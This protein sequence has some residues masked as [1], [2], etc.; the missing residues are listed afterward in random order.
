MSTVN[1]AK[2]AKVTMTIS[3]QEK[4]P[5]P[6]DPTAQIQSKS[7]P[8]PSRVAIDTFRAVNGDLDSDLRTNRGASQ[9]NGNDLRKR[10]QPGYWVGLFSMARKE[11]EWRKSAE[12]SA[13]IERIQSSA[14]GRVVISDE[15][16]QKAI[17][18]DG[19]AVVSIGKAGGIMLLWRK[20]TISGK[21]IFKDCQS[22]NYLF[23]ID[24]NRTFLLSCLYAS[25]NIKERKALWELL[26][27]LDINGISWL[28]VGDMNCILMREE[29][30]G[31]R[32]FIINQSV[33]DF[34]HFVNGTGLIDAG[35]VG[36]AFT[37]TNKRENSRKISAM[38]DRVL[39]D[40]KWLEWRYEMKVE[41]KGMID[42]DHR[43]FLIKC[44]A[45]LLKKK[46][47]KDKNFIC[48]QFWFEYP[49]FKEVVEQYWSGNNGN[50]LSM[51]DNIER[52]KPILSNWN[53]NVVGN[54]ENKWNETSRNLRD[55][56]L[57][58]E[59]GVIYDEEVSKLDTDSESN[60][61]HTEEFVPVNGRK[62]L[63]TDA[64]WREGEK[65]GCG[66][67]LSM[68]N[69]MLFEGGGTEIAFNPL[70][71]ELKAICEHIE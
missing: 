17:W 30:R 59:A 52:L 14:K 61:S 63:C 58:E 64:S 34:S 15:D 69:V 53:R 4:P 65:V 8:A 66:F 47:R 71:A 60:V 62:Y 2:S 45:G 20:I 10:L 49:E 55:L 33:S 70:H 5:D 40:A 48:E 56:E 22:I 23:E 21:V 13:K 16:L 32:P 29:K 36:P 42:S 35:F 7:I 3:R 18:W 24:S 39:Y 50:R 6:P 28:I 31:G 1:E 19:E 43:L 12:I 11:D 68:D 26:G 54:L 25:N 51:M 41:H 9:G 46:K 27:E 44:E 57:K 38:L 37:W 67:I